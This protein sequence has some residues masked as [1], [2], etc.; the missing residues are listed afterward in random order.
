[1][2]PSRKQLVELE[3][4]LAVDFAVACSEIEGEQ[5]RELA[6]CQRKKLRV[7]IGITRAAAPKKFEQL[8]NFFLRYALD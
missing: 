8:R 1:M 5:L 2:K 3:A 6:A 7:K 4:V